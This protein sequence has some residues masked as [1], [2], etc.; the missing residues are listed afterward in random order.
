MG[1]RQAGG[2]A[3]STKKKKRD[4]HEIDD[5]VASHEDTVDCRD[6]PSVSPGAGYHVEIKWFRTHFWAGYGTTSIVR[7]RPLHRYS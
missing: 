7:V 3:V 5:N 1:Q 2:Y 4:T 6:D